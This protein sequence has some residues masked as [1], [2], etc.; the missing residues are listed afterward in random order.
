ME[1]R[2]GKLTLNIGRKNKIKK[3]KRKK[4]EK[5]KVMSNNYS[6]KTTLCK[7]RKISRM[8]RLKFF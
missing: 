2:I 7:S 6:E 1:R 4:I 3:K 8:V 5:R